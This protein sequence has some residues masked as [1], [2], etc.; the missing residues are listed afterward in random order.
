VVHQAAGMVKVQLDVPIADAL[1]RL[2]ATAYVEGLGIDD[3]AKQV[4]GRKR[5]FV[6]DWQ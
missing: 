4:V 3:L 6:R 1:A 5:R 2:R